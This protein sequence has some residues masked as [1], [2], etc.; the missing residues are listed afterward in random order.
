MS[1]ICPQWGQ[2][3]QGVW[4]ALEQKIANDYAASL[5]HVWV[6][7]GPIFGNN[8]QTLDRSQLFAEI[9]N[10]PAEQRR[11]NSGQHHL[12]I[13][14]NGLVSG[15]WGSVLWCEAMIVRFTRTGI[16]SVLGV[17]SRPDADEWGLRRR[18]SR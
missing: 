8:P 13:S 9:N 12:V 18:W 14:Q 5:E 3:N 7:I 16:I 6:L 10:Q 2:M 17:S 1:N 15:N 11:G 4:R